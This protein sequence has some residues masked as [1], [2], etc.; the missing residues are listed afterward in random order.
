MHAAIVAAF[1][2]TVG[3][4]GGDVFTAMLARRVSG[5]ASMLL[6]TCLKLLLYI[7]FMLLWHAEYAG[8][9]GRTLAWIV[10]LGVLFTIAYLGFN[11]AMQLGKNPA[12]VGVVAG[13]F[14][15]S[16]AV[17][18]IGVFHQRPSLLT[19]VLLL[20]VLA[21]VILMGIPA[22][23][24]HNLVLDKGV[25]LALV[26]LVCWGMFATLLHEPVQQLRTPHA[27]FVVQSLV[28]VVMA[29]CALL[30]FNRQSLHLVHET[31]RKRAAS[32]VLVAGLLIGIAEALQALALGSGRQLVV[33]E[34]LIGSYPAAY[35]LIA[36]KIFR[37]PLRQ[38][39]WAGIGMVAV[40]II[41]LS[42][43]I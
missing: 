1:G 6:L 18:A 15:A 14:P 2:A 21:G 35:F 3:F 9:Q 4:A 10:L 13:C 43:T 19:T 24:R 28:A 16:A 34:A 36:H 39:Q 25:A 32:L 33:I 26:P 30:V 27:W 42:S 38:S 40:A 23:W 7:P 11:M 22:D 5:K 37:E 8:L 20:V 41:W 12:L 29:I 17:M 31:W